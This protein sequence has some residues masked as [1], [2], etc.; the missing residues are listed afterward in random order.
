MRTFLVVGLSSFGMDLAR[1]LANDGQRVLTVDLDESLSKQA[2]SFVDTAIIADA[3]NLSRVQGLNFGK[4]DAAIV[5]LGSELYGS[6]QTIISL[7]NMGIPEIIVKV[8]NKEHGQIAS[9]VGASRVVHPEKEMAERVSMRIGIDNAID[10]LTLGSGVTMAE[11]AVPRNLIGKTLLEAELGQKFGVQ[12]LAVKDVL[13]DKTH[14]IPKP[15]MRLKDSDIL[16]ITGDERDIT[17]LR[18]L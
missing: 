16:I 17:K 5:C 9:L 3:R 15:D 1:N 13:L 2:Q 18:K 7:K 12:I 11:L 8:M 10:I 14:L 4:V 6:L